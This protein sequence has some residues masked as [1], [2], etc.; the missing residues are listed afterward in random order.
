[1]AVV[2]HVVIGAAFSSREAYVFRT[3]DGG[4]T[5]G[6]VVKLTASD[7]AAGDSFGRSWP[8]PAIPSWSGPLTTTTPATYLCNSGS[9]YVFDPNTPFQPTA[10]RRPS[11]TA[12]PTAQPTKQVDYALAPWEISAS[13][14]PVSAFASP[15]FAFIMRKSRPSAKTFPAPRPRRRRCSRQRS[16]CQTRRPRPRPSSASSSPTVLSV[17]NKRA[18]VPG[19]RGAEAWRRGYHAP[20]HLRR[21]SA[22]STARAGP[23]A[24]RSQAVLDDARS[25]ATLL[26]IAKVVLSK[27]KV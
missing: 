14:S 3:T 2:G 16:K 19:R 5:Y 10:G 24:G 25:S 17:S 9:V 21:S 27:F 12:Q 6:Q 1:M 15:S 23:S 13:P 8:S 20:P 22:T 11:T 18:L 26:A 7:A 4:A